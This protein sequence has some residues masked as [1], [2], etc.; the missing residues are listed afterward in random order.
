MFIFIF[1]LGMLFSF[2]ISAYLVWRGE[3]VVYYIVRKSEIHQL[4]KLHKK[5]E[6]LKNI[7]D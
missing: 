1:V 5:E 6:I 4:K 7:R 3:G 2:L